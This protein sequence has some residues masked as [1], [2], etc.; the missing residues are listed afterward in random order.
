MGLAPWFFAFS[1]V[2][3][4]MQFMKDFQPELDFTK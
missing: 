2:R 3:Q 1:G 4:N